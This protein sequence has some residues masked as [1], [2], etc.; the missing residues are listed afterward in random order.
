M[1]AVDLLGLV[2]EDRRLDR[3]LEELV[4]VAAEELVEGV[5]AGHVQREARSRR[6][7]RPH[8]WRRLATVPGK[9]T[10]I[11]ASR[12]PT[13][14]PELERVGGH[15]GQQLALGQAALDLAPLL[16]R[17]AGAVG[18]DPLGQVA[19]AGVLEPQRG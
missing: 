8:I 11:A 14:M 4:R 6:P 3:A 17:V 13:S 9:V 18:R 2:V 1:R 5:V 10:Q 15:H 16:G 7:A 12:S 19:A